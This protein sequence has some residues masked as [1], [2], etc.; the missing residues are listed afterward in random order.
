MA[1]LKSGEKTATAHW[2][3]LENGSQATE[4][5]ELIRMALDRLRMNREM[6]TLAHRG[7][8]SA[9]TVILNYDKEKL[10]ID[11]PVDWPGTQ[12]NF[13]ILF[14]DESL[15]WNHVQVKILRITERSIFAGFPSRLVRIQRRANYRVAVPGESTAVFSHKEV[16]YTG[17]NAVNISA[18]GVLIRG[19]R[20]LPI[21]KGDGIS[22]LTLF[23][24]GA[25]RGFV[26]GTSIVIARAK[27]VRTCRDDTK[28]YCYGVSFDLVAGEEKILLQ[29]VRQRERE[30][31]RKGLE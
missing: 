15:I 5:P 26:G 9:K 19:E 27:V 16:L 29:Y 7:Y 17:L 20:D 11:K 31:L 3:I 24:P 28:K 1:I 6:I 25:E 14:R 2:A 8:E 22:A 21:A 18:T 23:F 10:E 13:L 30:L 12:E 4:S